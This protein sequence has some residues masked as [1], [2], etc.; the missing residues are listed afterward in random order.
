[1]DLDSDCEKAI[2]DLLDEG[3]NDACSDDSEENDQNE[4]ENS[5]EE[6]SVCA[7]EIEINYFDTSMLRSSSSSVAHSKIVPVFKTRGSPKQGPVGIPNDIYTPFQYL[8]LFWDNDRV[9]RFFV[10]NIN[11]Y[12]HSNHGDRWRPVSNDELWVFFWYRVVY[13]VL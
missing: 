4:D 7:R 6:N 12:G 5:D 10:D 8:N 2:G 11:C 9:I 3:Q 1:L 13:W